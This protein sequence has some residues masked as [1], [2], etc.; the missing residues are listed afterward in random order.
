MSIWAVN[1]Y[2]PADV[3][4]KQFLAWE[5][6]L[7]VRA[8]SYKL[9]TIGAPVKTLE[10]ETA[11][12]DEVTFS[13]AIGDG[14][15]TGWDATTLVALPISD[16]LGNAVTNYAVLKIENEIVTV[17]SVD[18][19]TPGAYTVDVYARWMGETTGAIHAD[20]VVADILSFNITKGSK[21][22]EANFVDKTT[23]TNV[24]GKYTVPSLEFTKEDIN[25]ERE[26]YGEAGYEDF[27]SAQ[28]L[29]KDKTL[30]Q[31]MN[32]ALLHGT[33]EIGNKNTPAMTRGLLEE[34][35]LKGN[36]STSFGTIDSLAK[37]DDAL[38]ASRNKMWEANVLLC[39]PS[40]FDAI[41]KLGSVEN[42]KPQILDRLNVELGTRV[43]SIF[44]KV[45]TLFLVMD[46]DM[47][48]DKIVIL[49]TADLSFHPL[50]GFTTPG[51]DKT[52]AQESARNDQSF[53]YDTLAQG[54]TYFQNSNK[55]MTLIT[56]I[57]Y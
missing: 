3:V 40:A 7:E 19:T 18:R 6:M 12:Q 9:F 53:V 17:K 37:I 48:N 24:V 11:L 45:G 25:I 44:T 20:T 16:A 1:P 38:T 29:I 41:Q 42:Q 10:Y 43:V 2:E 39:W 50:V 23:D 14:A 46:L 4:K 54:W 47:P 26:K 35:S 33:K 15:G 13:G 56:D 28:I 21:D 22:I 49:N 51:W 27:I 52:T 34:A 32:K 30:I 57:S 5:E 8:P 31:T 36:V 55:N